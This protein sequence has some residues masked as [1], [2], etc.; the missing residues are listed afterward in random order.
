MCQLPPNGSHVVTMSTVE[1]GVKG[2]EKN[3]KKHG[4]IHPFS[5]YRGRSR[6]FITDAFCIYLLPPANWVVLKGDY[7]TCFFVELM[8]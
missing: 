8:H 5:L 4:F 1:V 6:H 2:V 3:K 7:I